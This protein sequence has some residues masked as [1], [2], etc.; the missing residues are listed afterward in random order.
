MSTNQIDATH[1]IST[2]ETDT[3]KVLAP[4]GA[5]SV[6]FRSAGAIA[7]SP[8]ATVSF[9]VPNDYLYDLLYRLTMVGTQRVTL[10][11]TADLV[12]SDDFRTRQRIVLAG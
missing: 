6:V 9:T 12:L 4:D 7:G 10:Q 1:Q 8:K 5:G 11:G 3:T 2:S